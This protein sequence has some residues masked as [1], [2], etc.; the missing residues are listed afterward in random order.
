MY[1]NVV[2][3]NAATV[4]DIDATTFA[5]HLVAI[6]SALAFRRPVLAT[7]A[8]FDGGCFLTFDDGGKSALY[9]IAPL[10][11]AFGWRG[12]FFIITRFIGG[13]AC[14]SADQIREL[15]ARGHEIGSHSATHPERMAHLPADRIAEEWLESTERLSEILGRRI[16]TA[17]VPNGD[18]SPQVATLAAKAGIEVLF[19]STPTTQPA[20]IDGCRVY[21]RF[22]IKRWMTARQ[23]AAF[24]RGETSVELQQR[25]LWEIKRVARAAAGP[26]YDQTR[27]L[28]LDRN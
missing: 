25:F 5:E 2:V 28:L 22:A 9:T 18:Y 12:H 7:E 3:R 4:Y 1:H 15:A 20:I 16:R 23:A 17:S 24:A 26:L 21:G 14:M 13:S 8:D 6:R 19:T 11:E 10:L 27:R